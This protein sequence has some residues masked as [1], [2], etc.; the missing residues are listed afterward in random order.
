MRYSFTLNDIE[1]KI[2]FDDVELCFEHRPDIDG[3]IAKDNILVDDV[4]KIRFSQSKEKFDKFVKH[5]QEAKD[6]EDLSDENKRDKHLRFKKGEIYAHIDFYGEPDYFIINKP[7]DTI[8]IGDPEVDLHGLP[9][10]VAR[11]IMLR[12]LEDRGFILIRGTG[13]NVG[14]KGCLIIGNEGDGKTTLMAKMLEKSYGSKFVANDR[15]FIGF[16]EN[17]LVMR[18]FAEPLKVR[19]GTIKGSDRLFRKVKN[20]EKLENQWGWNYSKIADECLF[21]IPARD[22]DE[23]F[24][25]KLSA[26]E[27]IDSIILA[28]MVKGKSDY[29]QAKIV[30]DTDICQVLEKNCLSPVSNEIFNYA[31]NSTDEAVFENKEKII[32]EALYKDMIYVEFSKDAKADKVMKAIKELLPNKNEKS[33]KSDEEDDLLDEE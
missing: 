33:S 17:K 5:L 14:G 13:I 6:I 26:K 12:K 29:V 19:M 21:D 10:K 16:E 11:S 7:S 2:Y 32:L 30:G 9:L 3:N 4:V 18:T 24:N 20:D 1:F 15:I 28:K 27:P 22:I 31:K 23:I 8:I 25:C